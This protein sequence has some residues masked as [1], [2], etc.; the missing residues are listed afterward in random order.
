MPTPR[1]RSEPAPSRAGRGAGRG[2]VR[3]R[4]SHSLEAVVEA[5]VAI[6]DE[7]GEAALTFRSLAARLGGGVGSIYWYVSSKDE[8]L[9][10]ASDH[11]LAGV[12]ERP[13]THVDGDDPLADLRALAIVLF[14][15]VAERHWL[16]A[17]FMRNTAAQPNALR[18]FERM[19]QHVMRLGL[20]PKRTFDAVSAVLG[21]VIGTGADLA[22]QPPPEVLDGSLDRDQFMHR[23]VEEWEALDPGEFPFLHSILPVF[24]EHDDRE[25][26]VAGLDL[27]LAGLR[28]QA[29]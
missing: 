10:R 12:L 7:E 22:T 23:V 26:F 3:R 1:R 5:T 13:D 15:V 29:G 27:L 18:V 6:L 4:A 25:Q 8:L 16:A 28:Q 9:D 2:A 14:D 24:A 17:Y 11:V 20:G 21:F 19:G